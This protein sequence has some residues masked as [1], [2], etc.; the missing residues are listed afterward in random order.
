M[1]NTRILLLALCFFSQIIQAQS[2]DDIINKNIEATGGRALW[3]KVTSIKA[4]GYYVLGPG[5]QAPVNSLNTNKPFVGAYSDFSW[6]GMTSK[7]AM[8][9]SAGWSYNP[10]GGKRTADPLSPD[11]L[12]SMKLSAD[13]QGLLFNYKEKK[14]TAEYLGMDDFDGVEVHKI[15]VTNAVGDL[16]YYYIDA[17]NFF[18]FKNGRKSATC[19]KGRNQHYSLF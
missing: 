18:C 4:S 19:R 15:R 10:F 6:Q 1:L 13:P 3:A 9:D 8:K 7:S 16:I 17:S 5:M 12:R 2:V 14:C 11:R